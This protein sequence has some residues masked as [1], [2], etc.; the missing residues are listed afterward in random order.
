MKEIKLFING[1]FVPSSDGKTFT[2]HSSSTGEAIATCHLPSTK[3]IDRA[4]DAADNA[5][6]N[7]E[8][9]NMV[10]KKRA[11][12]L[13]AISEKIKE[14]AKELVALEIHDSGST[15]RKA[16]AD[17]HNTASFFKVMS[18]VA[19]SFNFEEAD[20]SASRAG[21]SKN[22]R[23]YEPVG[24]CAQ[25]IPW[26]FPLVMAGWKIGPILATGCT[27]VLKS[28]QET[29]V[30]AGIL[31]EI[32]HEC[33]VPAGVVNIVTGGAEHGR[34]LVNHPKVAKVAFTGSTAVGRE[35]L[36]GSAE[37]I[38]TTTLELGG[39]SANIV[40]DD[41]DLDIA[42]DGALYAFL[43]HQGQACDS[44]TRLLV[45]DGIYD[46]FMTRFL[47]RINDIKIGDPN[48]ITT[49]FGPVINEKQFNTI[50]G[51][52]EKSKSE[53][54]KLLH[55][56]KRLTGGV[57]D[58]GF[59]IE[60]T[61]FEITPDHTIFHEEIFGPVVGITRFNSEEEAINLAN[62]SIYGLAGAVWS[63][64]H[65]RAQSL[66]NKLETGTVW[67]NEY[68]L[69]NPGM[70]FGGFKQSGLGREM[71]VEGMRAYLEVKHVWISD[72]DPREQK[73]WFDALF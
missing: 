52:I 37:T 73:P 72:C 69:L 68:H 35:I 29:P 6:H 56:G 11:E 13:L 64:N 27:T 48:E 60:P 61:A 2:S 22:I 40:L 58:K 15:V 47:K 63:K 10:G 50:M 21:F 9:R 66:A 26:N 31:A 20:E 44:G 67:I 7:P 41:A 46:E 70:P 59:Y 39:K 23:R 1:E 42:V 30:T 62:N 4:V 57:F 36:K 55:G 16:K 17:V 45:Q 49:G 53:G 34:Q 71:G 14:R 5:F 3:D 43:Y 24:V 54:A 12:I 8:W 38:K 51:Y 32:L 25:I 65:E 18:K 33:G 28:A 19:A